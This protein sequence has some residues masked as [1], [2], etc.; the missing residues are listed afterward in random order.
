M[1]E[2]Q[3]TFVIQGMTRDV[4]VSKSDGKY[5]YEIKNMRLTAQEGETLLSLVNEKGN[6]QY[7]LENEED[8]ATTAFTGKDSIVGYCV[9]NK[10]LVLFTHGTTGDRIYS[11]HLTG[12]H[13]DTLSYQL[14][15]AGDLGFQ[16][17]MHLDT[18][19]I[20]E[21][22]HIQKVYWIDGI[23]QPRFINIAAD[24]TTRALWKKQQTPFDFITTYAGTEEV[25]IEKSSYS[26]SFLPG[27]VQYALTYYNL[28]GQQTNVFYTSPL[29]YTAPEDRGGAANETVSNSFTITVKHADPAFDYL[30]IYRVLRTVADGE[31]QC[32][33]VQDIP[34]AKTYGADGNYVSQPIVLTDTGTFGSSVDP[35]EVLYAGGREIIPQTMAQKD[36]TLFFGNFKVERSMFDKALKDELQ[37]LMKSNYFAY[38]YKDSISKGNIGS[39]YMYDNQLDGNSQQITTFKG[40]ETYRFGLVFQDEKGEWS[41]VVYLGDQTNS[42]YPKDSITSFQP[43][44]GHFTIPKS[45]SKRIYDKGYRKVKGVAVYPTYSDRSVICQGVLCPTVYNITDR[46]GNMPY[47]QSSWFFRDIHSYDSTLSEGHKNHC[48]QNLHNHNISSFAGYK[49]SKACFTDAEIYGASYEDLWATSTNAES[50]T[51]DMFVDWNVVTLHSPDIELDFNGVSPFHDEVK[52]RIVGAIP[53]TSSSSDIRINTSTGAKDNSIVNLRKDL[54][55]YNNL[56]TSGN[57]LRISEFDW[58]DSPFNEEELDMPSELS[59]KDTYWKYPILPWQRATTLINQIAGTDTARMVSELNT[60]IISNIRTSALTLYGDT[61]SYDLSDVG[62]YNGVNTLVRLDQD[63][64]NPDFKN[65]INYYGESNTLL[66]K[67]STEG[68]QVPAMSTTDNIFGLSDKRTKDTVQMKYKSSPHAVLQLAYTGEG[69]QTLLPMLNVGGTLLGEQQQQSG[70][71]PW[72]SQ[73]RSSI[74]STEGSEDTGSSA[75]ASRSKIKAVIDSYNGEEVNAT[76]ITSHTDMLSIDGINTTRTDIGSF[77]P[78]GWINKEFLL[79]FLSYK[80]VSVGDVLLFPHVTL[81]NSELVDNPKAIPLLYKV[82]D[83]SRDNNTICELSTISRTTGNVADYWQYTGTDGVTHIY[84]VDAN[85]TY[86]SVEEIGTESS[87]TDV[88]KDP[89]YIGARELKAIIPSYN[90]ETINSDW[91]SKHSDLIQP[92]GR[93]G[94]GLVIHKDIVVPYIPTPMKG[95]VIIFPNYTNSSYGYPCFYVITGTNGS[96][97]YDSHMGTV[98]EAADKGVDIC[99]SGYWKYTGSDGTKYLYYANDGGSAIAMVS[100]V[101]SEGGSIQ[102]PIFQQGYALDNAIQKVS[103]IESQLSLKDC[104]YLYVAELYREPNQDSLFG[105]KTEGA[106]QGNTWNTAGKAVSIEQDGETSVD[107]TQGDTYYQR[108][109]CLKTYPCTSED[110]NQLVEIL[111]FMCETRVN[112]DGR[113]DDNRGQ[114][115]NLMMTPQNFNILNRS[116][117][118][119]DNYFVTSYLDYDRNQEESYPNA[120]VWSMTK[121]SGEEVDSWTRVQQTSILSLDGDK[122]VIQAL[123]NFNNNLIV[124][125]NNGI[126]RVLYNERVQI[127]TNDGVPIEIANSNKVQG[128]QYVSDHIGCSNKRAIAGTSSGLYFMDGNSKDIYLYGESIQSLSKAKGFNSWLYNRDFDKYR[129]FF[130]ETASDVYFIDDSSCLVYNEQLREFTGFYSYEGTDFMFNL[131][132]QLAAIRDNLLWHQFAGAYNHFFGD[133]SLHYQP[134]WVTCINNAGLT[135]KTYS[136]IDFLADS[137]DSSGNLLSTTFDTLS[138]WNEY[139]LGLTSLKTLNTRSRYRWSSLKRKYRVWRAEVPR[140][141]Y[142]QPITH[143]E[144]ISE[145]VESL[146]SATTETTELPDGVSLKSSRDRIRSP[147]AYVK[148]SKQEENSDKTILHNLSINYFE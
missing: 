94:Q 143:I 127:S 18:L 35:Y 123:K 33:I 146:E 124:F 96:D 97:H 98:K 140:A 116:Y 61:Q 93:S 39:L 58:Y 126:A 92:A 43:V 52:L 85:F 7:V 50:N 119:H 111:S 121:T 70:T 148:L 81:N 54:Y 37:D 76:W 62:L 134:Y 29:Y 65:G 145:V 10:I 3:Q 104:G 88:E 23:H 137:W 53:L 118:Q 9:L 64:N 108:Y 80:E 15:Y 21:S 42:L 24:A 82:T 100:F 144:G 45:L 25:S 101:R 49:E 78:Y 5:A 56:S 67:Q 113:C 136:T 115:S 30:R 17:D 51:M 107:F 2:K 38:Q 12:L 89:N 59:T 48:V 91:V 122:G 141:L 77:P 125:Q 14:L 102:S 73:Y 13:K 112:I 19:G 68:Y 86:A 106:L 142:V 55:H 31:A 74:G 47:A 71:L 109:D 8:D 11:M 28:N 34:I 46:K 110:H 72:S 131:E 20:Y 75:P 41:N 60:K 36:N 139:Q 130:D 135:D 83:A 44:K 133:D 66:I 103:G 32:R 120:L 105:G 4:S 87:D 57:H 147:W 95:D 90:G 6:K 79:S 27:T 128:S 16:S 40:G 22:E 69:K 63:S 1:A 117:T 84:K 132:D 129:I 114:S 138:L 99:V 26:G